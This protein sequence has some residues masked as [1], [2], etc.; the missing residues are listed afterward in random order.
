MALSILE[1]IRRLI[2]QDTVKVGGPVGNLYGAVT[3]DL[4]LLQAT[5]VQSWLVL[6]V[7]GAA[8][9][10]V[11]T[12]FQNYG[13]FG[14]RMLL[15]VAQDG[16]VTVPAT[17][18]GRIQLIRTTATIQQRTTF[19]LRVAVTQPGGECAVYVNGTLLRRGEGVTA[20]PITLDVGSH[21]I[22]VVSNANTTTITAPTGLE[23]S[24]ETDLPARPTWVSVTTNYLDTS[25]GSA[26][27]TLTWLADP[28]VGGYYVLR[29][30]RVPLRST[31][32]GASPTDATVLSYGEIG[33]DGAYPVVMQGTHATQLT[34]GSELLAEFESLGIISQVLPEDDGNTSVRLRL[35]PGQ[36][37]PP[38]SVIGNFTYLGTFSPVTQVARTTNASSLVYVD[39]AVTFG[40]AYEYALV[41]YGLV[42]PAMRSQRSDVIYVV[43]GDV[44]PPGSI[45]F[46][47]GYPVVENG[48]VTAR[49]TTPVDSDYQGVNIYLHKRVQNEVALDQFVDYTVTSVS[50]RNITINDPELPV[51]SLLGYT[52]RWDNG[53][54][55][56]VVSNTAGTIEVSKDLLP[57]PTNGTSLT[58]FQNIKIKTDYGNPNTPDEVS[59]TINELGR[60]VFATFDRARN[61]QK[62][63]EAAYFDATA[64][65]TTTK[66]PVVAFRQLVSGEQAYF[67]DPYKDSV[68]Y[69]IVELYGYNSGVPNNQKFDGVELYYRRRLDNSDRLLMPVPF[70]GQGFPWVVSGSGQAILDQH[71]IVTVNPPPVV[72]GGIL[73]RYVALSRT[74]EDNWIRVWAENAD[75]LS[76]DVLTFVVD[77]DDTPEVTSLE[78]SIDPTKVNVNNQP[79]LGP[80]SASF[81]AVIDD[82]TQGF[83]WWVNPSDPGEPTEAAPAHVGSL[84]I[85]RFN[86][87][88]RIALPLG[89]TKTL[90]VEPYRSW[91]TT[92]SQA[93]GDK[94]EQV[95]RLLVRTPRSYVAFENKDAKGDRSA[96]DVTAVF[97]MSP[98]PVKVFP[99]GLTQYRAGTI[100]GNTLQDGSAGWTPG[101]YNSGQPTAW[102]FAKLVNITGNVTT[103]VAVRQ[104]RSNTASV[105]EL[106]G[107]VPSPG[108]V[109]NYQIIDGSVFVRKRA[110]DEADTGTASFLPTSGRETYSRSADFYLDYY[111]TKN[112]CLPES[113]R[114]T[115]VDEDSVA[116]F[117]SLEMSYDS[118]SRRLTVTAKDPDDDCKYWQLFLKRATYPVL[119]AAASPPADNVNTDEITK[120]S[121]DV[122]YLRLASADVSPSSC[123]YTQTVEPGGTWYAIAVP[124]N[125]FNQQGQRIG[126]SFTTGAGQSTVRLTSL[127]FAGTP[128]T[129]NGQATFTA[130]NGA[131]GLVSVSAYDNE[132]PSNVVSVNNIALTPGS[133]GAEATG[134]ATVPLGYEVSA[135]STTNERTWTITGTLAGGNTANSSPLQI[136]RK[137]FAK[138]G[139]TPPGGTP[140]LGSLNIFPVAEGFCGGSCFDQSFQALE[141]GVSWV[142][143]NANAQ[144]YNI[145]ID[146]QV[147]TQSPIPVGWNISTSPS[148]GSF[149]Y[150]VPCVYY[151]GSGTFTDFKFIVTVV[152][153]SDG[154]EAATA[155]SAIYTTKIK[156][157]PGSG[158]GTQL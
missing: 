144:F 71:N 65:T 63:F 84:T 81:S 21:D 104:I 125:S 156:T 17:Q 57:P 25:V 145:R 23:L 117:G 90:V 91:N 33:A 5:P 32:Q 37:L 103:V 98:V 143:S 123:T 96:T 73:S 46:S 11:E 55:Y 155:T 127:E 40:Q 14:G 8:M 140:S 78:T 116:E 42:N 36:S 54:E 9:P 147:D 4:N 94:G 131:T 153:L 79:G 28:K 70:S 52:V 142:V 13:I 95:S 128:D 149:S 132:Y 31:A 47:E 30:Q 122:Q 93:E 89:R 120:K 74:R 34:V 66:L 48:F 61:E 83:R 126:K 137:F 151:A 146:L 72:S 10:D 99:T 121:L 115:Q 18:S 152:R 150:Q 105:L 135:T 27:N 20:I 119:G 124:Y 75:G 68:S 92:T 114:S 38:S 43:A 111:A 106:V 154:F 39:S 82:D 41:A 148:S 109:N 158:G 45:V 67:A 19:T 113:T 107:S 59:F 62:D 157:C 44:Q 80:G 130:T 88:H 12:F 101:Q 133:G 138:T 87:E 97:S 35:L 50:G 129:T 85:K 15:V 22:T 24:G 58:I 6:E 108:T 110:I 56:E 112:G 64:F 3:S 26:Q 136:T 49:F 77:Y 69:A 118:A 102:Y 141:L 86:V 29:R 16:G 76:T 2:R 100:S 134:V 60:Y 7:A 139:V 1:S 51:N 53:I